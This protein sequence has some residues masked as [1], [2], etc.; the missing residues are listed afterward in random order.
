MADDMRKRQ[1]FR[2]KG[3]FGACVVILILGACPGIGVADPASGGAPSDLRSIQQTL[4]SIRILA[5]LKKWAD[6]EDLILRIKKTFVH[7]TPQL[8]TRVSPDDVSRFSYALASVEEGMM[9]QNLAQF[10]QGYHLSE[11]VAREFESKFPDELD[12]ELAEMQQS[13]LH[14]QAQAAQGD[15][16][17]AQDYL[18]DIYAGRKRLDNA[19]LSYAKESWVHF[20]ITS[21]TF[22]RAIRARSLTQAK[23]AASVAAGDLQDIRDR[24]PGR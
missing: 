13:L 19:C 22:A 1:R 4:R 8:L 5:R 10:E 17:L 9:S 7:S 3:I 18:D 6:T 15:M 16:D 24:L 21:D 20:G 23:D 12:R 2:L 14:A 11:A